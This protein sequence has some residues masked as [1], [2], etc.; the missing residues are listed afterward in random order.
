[1]RTKQSIDIQKVRTDVK[2]GHTT[3]QNVSKA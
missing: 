3:L 2:Q 1:M